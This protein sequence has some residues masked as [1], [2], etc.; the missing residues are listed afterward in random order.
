MT[1]PELLVGVCG[2]ATEVGKTWASARLAEHLVGGRRTVAA[3]KP[4]QSFDPA[5]DAA[6]DAE[7]LAAATGEDPDHVCPEPGW[8]PVPMAPPMAAAALGR[9]CPTLA[10][11]VAG[12]TWPADGVDVGLVETVGGV[13][14]PLAEDGD[15]RDLVRALGVDLVVL[16]ADA[17]LGTIDAVRSGVDALAPLPVVVLLNRF[18]EADDLHRRNR[19]WLAQRDGL[20]VVTG[21]DG[22]AARLG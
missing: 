15:S 22:F 12:I 2:T 18:D 20:D 10:E 11:V 1:R 3:R 19:D 8:Y 9:P 16:V 7:V 4:L 14:S 6:T 13:R 21:V 5:D 17:G